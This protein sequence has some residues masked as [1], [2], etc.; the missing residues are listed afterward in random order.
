MG[1]GGG[2]LWL[3][4]MFLLGYEFG[5]LLLP[6]SHGWQHIARSRFGP[7]LAAALSLLETQLGLLASKAEHH[8]HH[9]HA[10][11]QATKQQCHHVMT[12]LAQC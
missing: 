5:V 6:M 10:S 12:S 3:N 4:R 7:S 11:T 1:N 9:V 2:L 8:P